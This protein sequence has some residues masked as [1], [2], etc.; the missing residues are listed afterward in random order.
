VGSAE[1][2]RLITAGLS[3]E[4]D[5]RRDKILRVTEAFELE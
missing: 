3:M 2:K 1:V 5:A 4:K